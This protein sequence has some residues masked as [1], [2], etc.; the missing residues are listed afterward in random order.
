MRTIFAQ[1][2]RVTSLAAVWLATSPVLSQHAGPSCRWIPGTGWQCTRPDRALGASTAAR[3]T[4]QT[5]A[6]EIVRVAVPHGAHSNMMDRGSG[7]LVEGPDDA[8]GWVLTA[9]H[10]TKH[11]TDVIVEFPD[12]R[13]YRGRVVR[14]SRADDAAL[15]QIARAHVRPRRV[16]EQSP[17]LG[18][19]VYLAGYAA[20]GHN[21]TYR[22][23]VTKRQDV[24]EDGQKLEVTGSAQNGTSGGPM[25]NEQGRV[26]SVISTTQRRSDSRRWTTAGCH[27]S[28]LRHLLRPFKPRVVPAKQPPPVEAAA[29]RELD[30]DKLASLVVA[31][32]PKPQRGPKGER[33]ERGPPGQDVDPQQ[34]TALQ[35]EVRD[36]RRQLNQAG[37]YVRIIDADGKVYRDKTFVRLGRTLDLKQKLV[38]VD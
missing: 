30:L 32:M 35:S 16:A 23:W 6:E 25:I 26:V 13:S 36:L 10:V 22:S 29:H 12:G 20:D 5:P 14:A 9:E 18:S 31:K 27:T 38:P 33:G 21:G 4:R 24:Y 1:Y 11:R 8:S 17:P 15:I 34:L 37:F 19:A 28:R 7:V 3:A 2:V